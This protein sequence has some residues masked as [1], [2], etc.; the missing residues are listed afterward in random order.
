M[1]LS[2]HSNFFNFQRILDLNTCMDSLCQGGVKKNCLISIGWEI[3]K[4]E[5][6]GIFLMLQLTWANKQFVRR[7]NC[8]FTL[9]KLEVRPIFST[10]SHGLNINVSIQYGPSM[11]SGGNP[12]GKPTAVGFHLFGGKPTAVGF[13]FFG[14]KP[15][16]SQITAF[17]NEMWW[18]ST[19][20]RWKPTTWASKWWHSGIN[21]Q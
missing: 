13:H 6:I 8:L 5:R 10:P 3:K 20:K 21:T 11:L 14:G 15:T 4:L 16:T 7:T 18:V 1:C 12:P 17:D 9:Y 2:K 19:P